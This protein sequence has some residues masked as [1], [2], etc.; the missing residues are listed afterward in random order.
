[1]EV[2]LVLG[3]HIA[4]A[5]FNDLFR[6]FYFAGPRRMFGEESES[7]D[8][9]RLGFISVTTTPDT[10]NTDTDATCHDDALGVVPELPPVG[11][12]PPPEPTARDYAMYEY[13]TCPPKPTKPKSPAP[14]WTVVALRRPR[15]ELNDEGELVWVFYY[16]TDGSHTRWFPPPPSSFCAATS[17]DVED[18][19]DLTGTSKSD[20]LKSAVTIP[21][22][23]PGTYAKEISGDVPD[24]GMDICFECADPSEVEEVELTPHQKTFTLLLPN[25]LYMNPN[26]T[27]KSAIA[28]CEKVGVSRYD[29]SGKKRTKNE[30]EQA[31]RLHFIHNVFDG[32][33]DEYLA[34]DCFQG[35]YIFVFTLSSY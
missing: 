14:G 29:A 31:L 12:R 15:C 6:P 19:I 4:R 24:E 33:I 5:T 8:L 11:V 13:P 25:K 32:E 28:E 34:S 27:Q 20:G 18:A 10:D 23:E 17:A 2:L 3:R 26:P 9:S 16:Y 7:P 1:M 35:K 30:L 22:P 21:V